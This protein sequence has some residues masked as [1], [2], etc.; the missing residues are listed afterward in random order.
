[1]RNLELKA[2]YAALG[3]AEQIALSIGAT[4]GGELHQLDTYFHAP[5]GRL[6]LREINQAQAELIY[7]ER[8]E[9]SAARWSDYFTAQVSDVERLR[10]ALTRALS[11]RLR[12]EKFRR[13]YLY[14]GARIHLD[15]VQALGTFIEFEVPTDGDEAAA[16]ATMSELMQAFDV[17]D[18]DA[19]RASYSEL[20]EERLR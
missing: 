8:L 2:R 5:R 9:D 11:I 20:M 13:L 17:R 1:M 19:I 7:Y 6:K 14:K 3:R 4:F 16:R 15:R 12:V 18:E 10:D